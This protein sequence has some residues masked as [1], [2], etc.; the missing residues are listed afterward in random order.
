MSADRAPQCSVAADLENVR[1][2]LRS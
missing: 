2:R 1:A